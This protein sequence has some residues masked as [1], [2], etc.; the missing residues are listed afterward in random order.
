MMETIE[1]FSDFLLKAGAPNFLAIGILMVVVWL[2]IP[3][4]RKGLHRKR[5]RDEEDKEEHKRD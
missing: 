5:S 4:I 1:T 2:L 3:G